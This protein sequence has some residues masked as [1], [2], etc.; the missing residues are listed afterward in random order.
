MF[1]S[2]PLDRIREGMEVFN[3][4]GAHLGTVARVAAAVPSTTH[5]PD[6]DL[7]DDVT[8]TVPSPPDMTEVSTL[9]A[10]GASPWGH[11]PADLPDLPDPILEHLRTHGFIEIDAPHLPES[12]RF[13]PADRITEVTDT[14][15]TVRPDQP[16]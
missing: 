14:Q 15:V 7:L 2:E 10:V 12:H 11:T 3:S 4:S 5:P 8:R 1:P 9:E 13:I 6:S 16:A